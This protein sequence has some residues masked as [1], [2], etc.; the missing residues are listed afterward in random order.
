MPISISQEMMREIIFDIASNYKRTKCT[1]TGET[2]RY[3]KASEVVIGENKE[4]V[5]HKFRRARQPLPAHA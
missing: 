4:K 1:I 5:V 2:V 3:K